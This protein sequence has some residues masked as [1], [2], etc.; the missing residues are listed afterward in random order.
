MFPSSSIGVGHFL[1]ASFRKKSA[2]PSHGY[3]E[4]FLIEFVLANLLK[5]DI[6]YVNLKGK[7]F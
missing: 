2:T 5:Y 7:L 3:I 6:I 1:S 4:P